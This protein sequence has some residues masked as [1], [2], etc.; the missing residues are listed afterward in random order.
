MRIGRVL[1]LGL[2]LTAGCTSTS[3]FGTADHQSSPGDSHVAGR[4]TGSPVR[5]VTGP[6][7]LPF[8]AGQ[9]MT[10]TGPNTYTQTNPSQ[11]A[12]NA[13]LA[14]LRSTGASIGNAL[15]IEPRVIPASDPT[16]LATPT[17]AVGADLHFRAAQ[18]YEGQGN[19]AGA[20]SHYQ[21]ALAIAPQDPR[22][23]VGFGRLYDG[24]NEMHR[25]QRL[26]EEA[27]AVDPD[28]CPALNSLGICL[29]KQGQLDAAVAHISRATQLQ[30][31][32]ARY[33]NNLANVLADSGRFGEAYAQLVS[34]HGEA[35]AHYNLGYLLLQQGKTELARRELELALQA[36]SYLH[37]ARA[38]LQSLD[39][40]VAATPPVEQ[41]SDP[42]PRFTVTQP[43]SAPAHSLPTGGT[44]TG[45]PRV[46]NQPA[47]PQAAPQLRSFP[48]LY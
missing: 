4:T 11:G 8:P 26:Y 22:I 7:S 5:S 31:E 48:P 9:Q 21:Q 33:K 37:Q 3:P 38:L 23:I 13:L 28:F 32:N 30:P 45:A 40:V 24:Q 46:G 2:L 16:S 12:G 1:S 44:I 10:Q 47:A 17:D 35:V 34:V 14:G 42:S 43:E 27:L 20:I 6:S 41:L 36:N 25:A 18:V 19:I 29:A 39:P 15:T